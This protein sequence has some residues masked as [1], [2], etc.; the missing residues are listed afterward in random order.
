MDMINR[1]LLLGGLG[2]VGAGLASAARAQSTGQGN[3]VSANAA[4]TGPDPSA[5]HRLRFAVIGLDHSH[6]YA[7]TDALIRGG[8]TLLRSMQATR[9][10]WRPISPA[11]AT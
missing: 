11:M 7:M 5:K 9:G 6:I 1:R 8:G 10:N 4:P 2:V 3:G